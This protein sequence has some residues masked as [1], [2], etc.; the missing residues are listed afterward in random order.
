MKKQKQKQKLTL[1]PELLPEVPVEE[2]EV[3]DQDVLFVAK[4]HVHAGLFLIQI[5]NPSSIGVG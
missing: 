4:N 1:P 2:I 3:S 5:L